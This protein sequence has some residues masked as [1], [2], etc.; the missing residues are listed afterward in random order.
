MCFWL[1]IAIPLC[2]GNLIPIPFYKKF[3]VVK[4]WCWLLYF[5]LSSS[6]LQYL[7]FDRLWDHLASNLDE[8]VQPHETHTSNVVKTKPTLGDHVG[9]DESHYVDSE[10]GKG[11]SDKLSITRH[12]REWKGLTKDATEPPPLRSA[13]VDIGHYDEKSHRKASH[14]RRSESPHPPQQKKRSRQ[15][16][17]QH[18][19]V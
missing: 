8:Y 14:A 12:K 16:E 2:L 5:T 3:E 4:I 11:K 1:I 10:S 17:R 9:R 15:D 7:Y 18:M 6:V 13:V 19:K